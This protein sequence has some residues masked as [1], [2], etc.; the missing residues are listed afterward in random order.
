[1]KMYYSQNHRLLSPFD[2]L[3]H[4]LKK[5]D[6]HS[7]IFFLS[8]TQACEL[9]KWGKESMSWAFLTFTR[10]AG[11]RYSTDGKIPEKN[12][13][14]FVRGKATVSRKYYERWEETKTKQNKKA[15]KLQRV[16]YNRLTKDI[17]R[18]R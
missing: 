17:S 6:G 2:V 18:Q 5:P 15:E 11:A 3:L 4:I 7:L 10:Q 14:D 16:Y 1:M 8:K 12:S 13:Q 9:N